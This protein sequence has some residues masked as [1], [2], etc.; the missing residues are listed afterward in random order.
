MALLAE[1]TAPDAALQF[2]SWLEREA[3]RVFQRGGLPRCAWN[4]RLEA[5]GGRLLGVVDCLWVDAALVVE[6]DGLRFHATDKQRRGDQARQNGITL[7]QHRVL[8][9][10]WRDVVEEPARVVAEIRQALG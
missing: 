9:F 1:L 7:A 6:L 4:A 2:R 10:T 8:R 3:A 5:P